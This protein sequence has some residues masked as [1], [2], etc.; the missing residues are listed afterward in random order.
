MIPD[1]LNEGEEG[2]QEQTG[3]DTHI[4]KHSRIHVDSST[5]GFSAG[6][7]RSSALG[8]DTVVEK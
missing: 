5:V 2:N 7:V 3:L 4:V 6:R 1:R 8:E